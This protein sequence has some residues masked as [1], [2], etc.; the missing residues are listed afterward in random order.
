M[1][2]L[3]RH[4]QV[5]I[6]MYGLLVYRSAHTLRTYTRMLARHVTPNRY[7]QLKTDEIPAVAGF[8][9][10]VVRPIPILQNQLHVLVHFIIQYNFN[11]AQV[12]H[13]YYDPT[14]TRHCAECVLI[15]PCE[16]YQGGTHVSRHSHTERERERDG[17]LDGKRRGSEY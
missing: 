1:N 2:Q 6:G 10:S 9:P 3:R 16:L 14:G 17:V 7:S 8:D 12:F 15:S 4:P 5:H 11:E 13:Q